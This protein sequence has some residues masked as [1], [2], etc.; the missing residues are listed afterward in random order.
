[1]R[2]SSGKSR[3][4]RGFVWVGHRP[5]LAALVGWVWT[6]GP[7]LRK[8]S[9]HRHCVIKCGCLRIGWRPVFSATK[10]VNSSGF[11]LHLL[12]LGMTHSKRLSKSADIPKPRQ[13]R[14]MVSPRREP[15]VSVHATGKAPAGAIEL[16]RITC[17]ARAPTRG[18]FFRPCRGW[19]GV[20]RTRHTRL[21][22]GA[23]ILRPFGTAESLGGRGL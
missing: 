18:M 9:A 14:N 4:V 5:R 19:G 8:V 16:H 10:A 6:N 15:W 7:K 17:D 21:A 22:P 11:V 1:M 20:T 3:I 23:T 13:G 12:P 2:N